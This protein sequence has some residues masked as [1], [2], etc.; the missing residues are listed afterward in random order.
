MKGIVCLPFFVCFCL[1]IGGG[2]LKAED[3]DY[4]DIPEDAATI[5]T[6][7]TIVNGVL[8]S[9]DFDWFTFTPTANTLY[10]V[11]LNGQINSGYKEMDVYQI[12]EFDT[13]H[14]TIYHYSHSNGVSVRTFF[15][16]EADDVYIKMF[17]NPG[18]YAFY[19]EILGQYPPDSYSDDCAGATSLAVDAAPISGTLTHK[20][21][22]SLETDWFVFDTE[23]LHMYQ[24]NL[25]KSDNTDLNFQ[26]YNEDC[27]NVLGWAKSHTVTSWFGEPYKIYVAGNASHLGTYYTLE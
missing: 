24:I 26:V 10:R 17:S 9:G 5:P 16:E 21:D 11:T 12:D 22:G 1:F 13:L 14:K 6:D 27:E 7:G 4:G 19:I 3:P 15:L 2:I 18:G 23:P 20:P 8:D 25:T